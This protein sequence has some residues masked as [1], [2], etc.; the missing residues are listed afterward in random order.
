MAENLKYLPEVVGPATGPGTTPYYHVYNNNS[1]NVDA[2]KATTN[3]QNYG[4][5][6][7]WPAAMAGASSTNTNPSGVKG[8]CPSGGIS[9]SANHN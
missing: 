5:L 1:T 2:A 4:V 7:N 9:F 3:Y 6:Y 8:V